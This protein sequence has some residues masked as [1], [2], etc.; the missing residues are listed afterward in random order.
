MLPLVGHKPSSPCDDAELGTCLSG[1]AIQ[2]CTNW[3]M[4]K[5]HGVVPGFWLELP[6]DSI[7]KLQ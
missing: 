4:I 5:M 3:G 6:S 7:D 2:V 1:F